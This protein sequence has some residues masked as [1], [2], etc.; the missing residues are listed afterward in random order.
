MHDDD[1]FDDN[2]DKNDDDWESNVCFWQRM[3]QCKMMIDDAIDEN[4]DTN[5]DDD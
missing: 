5:D 2:Y 3:I 4:Y 1:D